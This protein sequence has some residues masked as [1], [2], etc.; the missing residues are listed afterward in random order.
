MF[1]VKKILRRA[2]NFLGSKMKE[3][4]V[5]AQRK[6]KRSSRKILGNRVKKDEFAAKSWKTPTNGSI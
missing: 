3:K 5:V 1:G 2:K 6:K 4:R